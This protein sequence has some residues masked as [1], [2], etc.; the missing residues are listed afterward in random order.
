MGLRPTKG[1]ED[2]LRKV[3]LGRRKRLPH[4]SSQW[5]RRFRLPTERSGGLQRSRCSALFFS[6]QLPC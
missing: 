6:S 1:D 3:G 5:G 2:A 4:I